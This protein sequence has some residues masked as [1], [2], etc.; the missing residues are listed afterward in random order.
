MATH[1]PEATARLTLGPSDA[2]R[3]VS[4]DEFAEAE[5]DEPWTYEREDGRLVV[6]APNGADH[7]ETSSPW[8]LRLILYKVGHPEVVEM[9][10]PNAWVR[11]DDGSD[12][13]G[14]LGVYLRAPTPATVR[15]PDRVPEMMFEI[16]SPGTVSRK[17]DY[18]K[19]RVDYH[20][21]GILE[22]VIVDR[23]TQGVTVLTHAADGYRERILTA[24]E[25]YESPHLPGLAIP[26]TEVFGP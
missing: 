6:M 5:F 21:L 17:R 26:L 9:V 10:V 13:I 14:D 11:V 3:L 24:G 25:T 18:I 22:Y 23:F 2:G 8:L 12:R 1:E 4:A 16:V 15:I 19:K 20:K 7:V